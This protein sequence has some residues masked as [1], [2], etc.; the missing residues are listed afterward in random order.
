M[1]TAQLMVETV[2]QRGST[3][4]W[5]AA[6]PYAARRIAGSVGTGP[7]RTASR[8]CTRTQRSGRVEREVL[9]AVEG[10]ELLILARDGD[11]A[12]LGPKSLSP[13][14]RFILDHA[15]CPVLLI[16][17]EPAPTTATIPPTPPHH[18]R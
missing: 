8:P 9:D 15:P 17:P 4:S 7:R 14:T 1:R 6:S 10:A 11:R 3:C 2:R 5:W 16:W 18:R 12:H 13:A